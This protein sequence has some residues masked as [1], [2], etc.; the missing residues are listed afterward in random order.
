MA[1]ILGEI[2]PVAAN[3]DI[4]ESVAVTSQASRR[5]ARKRRFSLK[6]KPIVSALLRWGLV[7]GIWAGVVVAGIVAYFSLTL[8]DIS[9]LEDSGRKPSIRLAL[10]DGTVFASSGEVHGRPIK[11]AE[12]PKSLP[13]AVMATEDRRF[14]GHF[15]LD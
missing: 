14:F 6:W 2:P 8:P 13:Q 4:R 12:M 3:H 15:G 10:A 1:V 5:P 11:L 9:S 7:A